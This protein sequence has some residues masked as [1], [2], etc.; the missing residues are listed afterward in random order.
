MLI[1]VS[2]L[3][4]WQGEG[5]PEV[6]R[7]PQR[8][9]NDA[10]QQFAYTQQA[11]QLNSRGGGAAKW[12]AAGVHGNRQTGHPQARDTAAHVPSASQQNGATTDHPTAVSV[13]FALT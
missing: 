13:P 9:I 1:S 10:N 7:P 2:T 5:V 12:G 8:G 4:E 6:E 3:V 11:N